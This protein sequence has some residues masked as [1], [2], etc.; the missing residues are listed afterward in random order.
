MRAD[1]K[2]YVGKELTVI[3][4]LWARTVASPDP[5]AARGSTFHCP[6]S[7]ILSSKTKAGK[8]AWVRDCSTG[9]RRRTRRLAL[10]RQDGDKGDQ[11][12]TV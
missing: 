12:R 1:L 2:P 9:M 4:W 7:F 3:A 11:R 10:R 6:S 8:Q 5:M